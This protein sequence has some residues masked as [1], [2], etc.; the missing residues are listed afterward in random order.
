MLGGRRMDCLDARERVN[1]RS[2]IRN[3]PILI[4]CHDVAFS[5]G[6]SA[7]IG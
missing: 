6:G 7:S 1:V 3:P 4:A 5:V 2:V